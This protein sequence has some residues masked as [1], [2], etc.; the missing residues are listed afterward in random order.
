MK[1]WLI[2]LATGAL[3]GLGAGVVF[4]AFCWVTLQVI[5]LTTGQGCQA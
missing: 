3:C 2:H 1:A 5:C 4:L